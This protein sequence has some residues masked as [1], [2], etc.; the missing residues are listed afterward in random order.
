MKKLL[1]FVLGVFLLTST[2]SASIIKATAQP[3]GDAI[4][5]GQ[6][7]EIPIQVDLSNLP[8][9]LGS[10]TAVLTW[11]PKA[12]KFLS[13]TAGKTAGFSSPVVNA[14]KAES[15][16][17]IF[18]SANPQ[19]ATGRV[20][21]LNVIF[22]VTP[23]FAEG[24]NL[25]LRFTAMAA[26][27]TFYDLLPYLS[28]TTGIED[29]IRIT[30]LPTEYALQQNYPNPFNPQTR[31]QYQLPKESHVRL[32]VYNSV[33]QHITT[34]VNDKKSAGHHAIMWTA[35]DDSGQLLPAGIYV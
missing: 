11:N 5:I 4:A 27:F 20:N 8:E 31:I 16:T 12:I 22:Q 26:A 9:A 29:N 19:G 13:Y 17:I 23:Q 24:A 35:T 32:N 14:D 1:A 33:G 6:K 10:Y 30:D 2:T 3:Q 7:I 15:G 28:V 21:I 34:L 18:A 25:D